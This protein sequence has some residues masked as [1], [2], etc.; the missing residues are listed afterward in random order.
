MGNP[1]CA[2]SFLPFARSKRHLFRFVLRASD[3]NGQWGLPPPFTLFAV[4]CQQK[5]LH[6]TL[7]RSQTRRVWLRLHFANFS[8]NGEFLC[9]FVKFLYQGLLALRSENQ[10]TAGFFFHN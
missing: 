4:I 8:E 5:L 7:K 6:D 2:I 9:R 10:K 3:F 1:R